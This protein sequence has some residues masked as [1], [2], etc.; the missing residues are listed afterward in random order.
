[1]DG[2]YGTF[3]RKLS[4]LFLNRPQFYFMNQSSFY[5]LRLDKILDASGS[6]GF[7]GSSYP[8]YRLLGIVMCQS[9][10]TELHFELNCCFT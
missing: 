5:G 10:S 6:W 3:R 9:G 2:F 4:S 7:R 1:M 8:Q